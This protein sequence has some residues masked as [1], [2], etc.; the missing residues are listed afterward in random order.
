MDTL[1]LTCLQRRLRS[2][3]KIDAN[4]WEFQTG[5]EIRR[6]RKAVRIKAWMRLAKWRAYALK[7]SLQG[8]IISLAPAENILTTR[9]EEVYCEK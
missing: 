1:S 8:E 2:G 3:L 4:V 7:L 6:I 9:Q 5:V